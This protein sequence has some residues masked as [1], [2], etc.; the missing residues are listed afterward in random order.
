MTKFVLDSGDP[1]EYKKIAKLAK[2]AGSELWGA[3]TNPS[4]IAKKLTGKKL[5]QQEAFALQ[6][7]LVLA[8]TKIVPGAVSAEV[9][10]DTHSTAEDMIGQGRDIATWHTRVVV[11]LPTTIEGFKARTTLRKEHIPVNNTLVFSQEQIFAICLHERISQEQF[12]PT[13][14]LWPPFISPFV[15]R[16]DD[17]IEDGMSLVE[18]GMILK[19]LFSLSLPKSQIAIWML[20]ASIRRV[21]HLKRSITLHS[22]LITAPAK[23]YEE[24]FALSEEQKESLDENA[25]AKTLTA[26]AYWNP[27]K[28]LMEIDTFEAFDN[29]ISSKKLSINHRL[30]DSGIER[31][32]ADWQAILA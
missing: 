26:P 9:Y 19:K 17:K 7:E 15:G 20:A 8:I 10:A 25:Y 31:F 32:T 24:W 12:G 21:E 13:D 2:D 23:M 14:N 6:K 30:T 4:L 27:P 16:L 29:A 3:T 28:E 18:H 22:E 5:T 11:K 1:D